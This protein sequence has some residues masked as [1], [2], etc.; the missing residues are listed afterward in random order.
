VT[1]TW[2]RKSTSSVL[3]AFLGHLRARAA[4]LNG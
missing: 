3:Q 1:M 2:L 4:N